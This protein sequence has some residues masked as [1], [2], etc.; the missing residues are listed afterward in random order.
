[1]SRWPT[2]PVGTIIDDGD[3]DYWGLVIDPAWTDEQ[4]AHAWN[5]APAWYGDAVTGPFE[6]R[7]L[8]RHSARQ[9]RE[10]PKPYD[11][12]WSEE[13]E[14]RSSIVVAQVTT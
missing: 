9:L 11:E 10:E 6:R 4:I 7:R 12:W 1:V 8:H 3:G 13:G 5:S 2:V 14:L